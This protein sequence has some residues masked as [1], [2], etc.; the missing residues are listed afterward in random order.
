MKNH[1][2]QSSLKAVSGRIIIRL[3]IPVFFCAL[4]VVGFG[5]AAFAGTVKHPNLIDPVRV[6]LDA[7]TIVRG[8]TLES[9]E[10][11]F[12]L[13]VTSNAVGERESVRAVLN[14]IPKK[15][16]NLD[17]EKPLSRIYV[18]D[19]YHQDTVPVYKPLWISI[20]WDQETSRGKTIKYWDSNYDSWIE[21]PSTINYEEQWV[22]AAIHLPFAIVGVFEKDVTEL[23]GKA[24][25]YHWYGA[26]MNNIPMGTVVEVENPATGKKA[27][28]TIVSTG[29]FVPGRIIDL[30]AEVFA[31]VGDLASGVIDVIVRV[32]E[33]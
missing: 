11:E 15:D 16:M 12:R 23:T 32:P 17:G 20:K 30:P 27:T 29:P 25:W 8:F 21:I 5:S 22:Q 4:A 10:R 19:V 18:F 26:A 13:G 7:I 24:S 33:Q 3:G 14:Q 6:R 9:E 1:S 31:S 28:T 2:T